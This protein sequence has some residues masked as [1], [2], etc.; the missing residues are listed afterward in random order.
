[1]LLNLL[2][3]HLTQ[4]YQNAQAVTRMQQELIL[5]RQG[6]E[7]SNQEVIALTREGHMQMM[8]SRARQWV[9]EYFGDSGLTDRLPEALQRWLRH[10]QGLLVSAD[11]VPAPREPLVVEREGKRLVIR[12][13]SDSGQSLLLVEEQVTTLSPVALK[14]LGLTRRETDVL[15]WVAQGRSN[16]A[17]GVLLGI[18][19][20]TVKKHL[21]HIYAKLGVWNRTEA[22][23]RARTALTSSASGNLP[24]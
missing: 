2:R 16:Y 22:A 14:P 18:S 19:E 8:T 23:E 21:E 12:L 7:R 1:M 13:L 6:M 3:P 5:A 10:R 9:A 20:P 24:L 4:A 11:E 15:A 17:I